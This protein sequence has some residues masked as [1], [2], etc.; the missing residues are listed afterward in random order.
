MPKPSNSVLSPRMP[1]KVAFKVPDIQSFSGNWEERKRA[2]Y[3]LAFLLTHSEVQARRASGLCIKTHKRIIQRFIERGH[4][5]DAERSGRPVVYTVAIME[6]AYELL[7]NIN[8]GFVTGQELKGLLISE[9]L[10]APDSDRHAF[11]VHLR[12]YIEGQGHRLI[13]NSVKTTFFQTLTD[14]VERLK[15]ARMWE[16]QLK[17]PG[18]LENIIFVDEVTLEEHPHPK[19]GARKD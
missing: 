5:F 19:G 10:L 14:I 9:G 7:T 6:R 8:T 2:I 3:V 13:T 11:M 16:E 1:R 15:Y 12:K 18:A 17:T 4:A